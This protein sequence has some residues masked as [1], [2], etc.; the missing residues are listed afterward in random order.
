MKTIKPPT[1]ISEAAQAFYTQPI[2][3]LPMIDFTSAEAIQR[4]RDFVHPLWQSYCDEMPGDYSFELITINNIRCYEI[5]P[6]VFKNEDAVILYVHGGSNFFGHPT[7][8]KNIPVSI[9][10]QSGVRVLSIEYRL[11]PEHIF[12]APIE[13][14][15][16]VIKGLDEY[17]GKKMSYALAGHSAGA[18]LTLS[19]RVMAKGKSL[20]LPKAIALL[21]PWVDHTVAGDT[22]LTLDEFCP[23]PPTHKWFYE[24]VNAFL[25]GYDRKDPLVSPL[26]SD[27]SDLCPIYIQA[28]G[29][30]RFL[31][32]SIQLNRKLLH[33][34]VCSTLDIWEG[35]WHGFQMI[36]SVPEA[37]AANQATAKFLSRTL[38]A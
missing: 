18:G 33:A 13:D 28:A 26:F 5:D 10:H 25:G 12:P 32:D 30:D 31:S 14:I 15:V 1:H 6:P 7:L 2:P 21:A 34:G 36:P 35:M 3:D 11:A 19:A 8:C 29:R 17:S 38:A 37:Q 16:A 4:V 20:A 23:N 22:W 24:S 27:L 9:A